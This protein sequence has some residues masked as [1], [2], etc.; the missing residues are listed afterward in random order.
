MA[1]N[2]AG[3]ID[4]IRRRKIFNSSTEFIH[5]VSLIIMSLCRQIINRSLLQRRIIIY[6][7]LIFIGGLL[8]DFASLIIRAFI[9]SLS[10]EHFLNQYFVKLAWFW[11][12]ILLVPLI[13][14]S[15]STLC[16]LDSIQLTEVDKSIEDYHQRKI[17]STTINNKSI[18][19]S[20]LQTNETGSNKQTPN[21]ITLQSLCQNQNRSQLLIEQY[22]QAILEQADQ[23]RQCQRFSLRWF[24]YTAK[25]IIQIALVKDLIRII[26]CSA[27]Y[28]ASISLFTMIQFSTT[29]NRSLSNELATVSQVNVISN[30]FDIS[31]HIFILIFSNL[32][33][34]E[35]CTIMTGWEPLG[36][37][38]YALSVEFMNIVI[39]S[40]QTILIANN[41]EM[42]RKLFLSWS[43]YRSHSQKL[44]LLFLSITLLSIIW[45]FMII[46]TIF[47]YHS[48]I[49]KL[50]A[51]LWAFISWYVCYQF[52]FPLLNIKVRRVSIAIGQNSNSTTT[53]T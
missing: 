17:N 24:G 1:Q 53:S 35:E 19:N 5:V 29:R 46:Q 37:R 4:T 51:M 7:F 2:S 28:L 43:R 32:M 34:I 16:L 41:I 12:M 26:I 23:C 6:L 45:D 13:M 11:N 22:K 36:D 20:S 48:L 18:I 30:G 31:G 40:Q 50:I 39:G 14:L 27:F 47:F 33:I 52:L 49:E 25:K 9:I 15:S 44:R 21:I 8:K 38:L 42:N 3:N 10:P